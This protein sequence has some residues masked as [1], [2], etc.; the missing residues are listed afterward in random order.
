MA[1]KGEQKNRQPK[2]ATKTQPRAYQSRLGQ[3]VGG[4]WDNVLADALK[5]LAVL[6]V[7]ALGAWFQVTG[8]KWQSAVSTESLQPSVEASRVPTRTPIRHEPTAI[9]AIPSPTPE[10]STPPSAEHKASPPCPRYDESIVREQEY[11]VQLGDTMWCIA[12]RAGVSLSAL[13][14]A[15]PQ[16]HIPDLIHAGDTIH[17]P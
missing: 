2:Q 8:D 6:F 10:P 1:K 16:I 7:L 15:N 12:E 14:A 9:S 17:I 11:I 5:A 13:I 3:L 4:V